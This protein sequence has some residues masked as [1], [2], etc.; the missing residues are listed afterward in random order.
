MKRITIPERKIAFGR[1][2]SDAAAIAKIPRLSKYLLRTGLPTTRTP[3]P[4]GS[5]TYIPAALPGLEAMFLNDI[6]GTCVLAAGY[7]AEA[8]ETGN[9][10]TGKPFI[11]TDAQITA[12]Y[13]AIGGYRPGDPS[14]DNGC[15]ILDALQ[16]WQTKG[17]ANGTKLAGALA[18][19]PTHS[20][21]V[22]TAIWLFEDLIIGLD[23]PDEWVSPFPSSNG[24][25]WDVAGEPNP[26]NG[27]CIDSPAYNVKIVGISQEGLII[28]TWGMLGL[29]TLDAL[30]TYGVPSAG[31]EVYTF[32]SPDEIQAGVAKAPNGLR[33]S[34]LVADFNAMGGDVPEPIPPPP[35]PPPAPVTTGP[36]LEDVTAWA[37][38]GVSRAWHPGITLARAN[39]AITRE[40]AKDWPKTAR[41][42]FSVHR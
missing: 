22:E 14:T 15:S 1:K 21:E 28:T 25:V 38:Q 40:L 24:F 33:W 11:A 2:H 26:E 20:E 3:A 18:V 23:L 12:D 8:T 6:L 13:E 41:T 9:A 16:Y 32:L 37:C 5:A 17:F 35:A 39:A 19:D 10:T 27:H 29:L 36:T 34:D 31:G 30:A 7:H 4:P 42:R